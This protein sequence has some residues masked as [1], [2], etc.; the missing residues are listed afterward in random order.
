MV[1]FVKAIRY[2][3]GSTCRSA[4]STIKAKSSHSRRGGGRAPGKAFWMGLPRVSVSPWENGFDFGFGW[5]K[6]KSDPLTEPRGHGG[7]PVQ[8]DFPRAS[9]PPREDGFAFGFR[10][11]KGERRFSRGGAG[12]RRKA[13]WI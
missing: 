8:M 13:Y 7:N 3:S 11:G 9:A 2:R 1:N 6:A 4:R 5:A 12:A 10:R